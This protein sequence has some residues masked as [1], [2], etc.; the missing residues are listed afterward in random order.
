MRALQLGCS[1][2]TTPQTKKG[3]T[4]AYMKQFIGC[5]AHK[6]YSVFVA[7]NERGEASQEVRV[8]HDREQYRQYLERLP[9]GSHIALEASGHYYWMVDEM[10]AAGHYPRLTIL[11]KLR[12]GWAKPARRPIS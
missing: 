2:L 11:W 3:V 9:A 4:A 7:V 6:K 10:E 5:D 12:S 8:G 1:T